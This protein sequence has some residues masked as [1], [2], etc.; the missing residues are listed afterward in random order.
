MLNQRAGFKDIFM[1]TEDIT[2]NLIAILLCTENHIL[3]E[4]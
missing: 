1:R 4:G 2:N 3:S